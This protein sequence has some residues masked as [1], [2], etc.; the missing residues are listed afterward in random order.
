MKGTKPDY[1]KSVLLGRL[2][3]IDSVE[4]LNSIDIHVQLISLSK[5]S[6]MKLL[7]GNRPTSMMVSIHHGFVLV[8]DVND[9]IVLSI[10]SSSQSMGM[11]IRASYE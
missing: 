1:S 7:T 6:D 3:H 9:S 4:Q 10:R 2:V 11:L 8:Q 5:C